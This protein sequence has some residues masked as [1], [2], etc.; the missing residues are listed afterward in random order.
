MAVLFV[1]VSRLEHEDK[2]RKQS[3]SIQN[4]TKGIGSGDDNDEGGGDGASLY[5]M[6][7]LSKT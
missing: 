7:E 3:S 4:A 1:V 2:R 5:T 6:S